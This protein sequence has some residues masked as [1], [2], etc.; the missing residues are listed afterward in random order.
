MTYF[1]HKGEETGVRRVSYK[2]H[3]DAYM[4]TSAASTRGPPCA[5]Q[6]AAWVALPVAGVPASFSFFSSDSSC[7]LFTFSCADIARGSNGH[8]HAS[9]EA[10]GVGQASRRRTHARR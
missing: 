7:S 10:V 5:S 9:L 6:E 4:H 2:K 1:K 8:L 3:V